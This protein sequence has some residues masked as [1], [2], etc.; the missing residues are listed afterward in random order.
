MIEEILLIYNGRFIEGISTID[1]RTFIPTYRIF[2]R[3]IGET[4]EI[5]IDS[6]NVDTK[7][8]IKNI[9][10]A[11]II[12]SRDKKINSIIDGD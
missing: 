4:I 6:F 1:E 9:L 8:V 11:K 2:D 10:D 5:R 12:E 7:V 3:S